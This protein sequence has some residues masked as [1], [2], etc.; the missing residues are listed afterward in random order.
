MSSSRKE[1]SALDQRDDFIRVDR[2]AVP[3][4]SGEMAPAGPGAVSRFYRFVYPNLAF[5]R[6]QQIECLEALVRRNR[7]LG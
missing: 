5:D 7:W 2:D 6:Q 3:V 4:F 1:K